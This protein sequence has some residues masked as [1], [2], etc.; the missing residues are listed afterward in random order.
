MLPEF[1]N[2]TLGDTVSFA[3]DSSSPIV[4]CEHG[5]AMAI[6]NSLDLDSNQMYNPKEIPPKNYLHLTWLWYVE[7][8]DE[9]HSI[10]ISRNRVDYAPNFKNK[11]M[12]G[13]FSE[14][15]VFAM[16][17]KMCLGIKKRA[18]HLAKNFIHPKQPSIKHLS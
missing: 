15:I 12:F 1:Q 10:F 4:I 11:L 8:L 14:P 18:E 5:R 13:S 17:R 9:N 3:P 7:E 2:T 16:D 6:E